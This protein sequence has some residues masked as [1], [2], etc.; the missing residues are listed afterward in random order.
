[1]TEFHKDP[2]KCVSAIVD[3]LGDEIVIATPLGLGKPIQLLNSFYNYAKQN[4]DV[5]LTI[6]SALS[7]AK[8]SLTNDLAKR[9][10]NPILKRLYDNYIELDY[11]LDRRAEKLPRNVQ[12]IEFY[13]S[14]GEY[15]HNS[16]AQQNYI[17]SNYTHVVRD[18][19]PY[20]INVIA[21]LISS[22]NKETDKYSLSCNADL[23]LDLIDAIKKHKGVKQNPLFLG[24]INQQLPYLYG[25]SAE[26]SEDQFFAIIDNQNTVTLFNI[27][28]P[29]VSPEDFM[30]GLY[31]SVL[32]KD[33][34][35]LQIGIGSLSDALVASLILRHNHNDN[36]IKMLEHIKLNEK[37]G[38][39]VNNVGETC[40]FKKGLFGSTEML[41]DGFLN[42]YQHHI[43]RKKVYDDVVL[44]KLLNNNLISEEVSFTTIEQLLAYKRISEKLTQDEFDFLQHYGIFKE[45]LQYQNGYIY[46][47]SKHKLYADLSKSKWRDKI[48]S[49]CLGDALKN[50]HLA[51]AG[52]FIGSQSL[53]E[54]L[55]N[56]SPEERK[57]FDMRG[58]KQ[59][60]QLYHSE[61][62]DALQRTN[63]R[64]VNSTMKVTL[65]GSAASDTLENGKVISG[66]GGQYNFVAMAHELAGARSIINCRSTY[67]KNGKV[68]SNILWEYAQT[69]IPRHLRDIVV[70]EYGI[71]DCRSKTDSDVIK[72]LLNISDSRFQ[73]EL[74]AKAKKAGKLPNDYQI[75]KPFKNNFP[76]TILQFL[77]SS[78]F[79]ECYQPY[80]FGTELTDDEVQIKKA[81]NYLKSLSGKQRFLCILK[82]LFKSS[83]PYKN[84]LVRMDLYNPKKIREFIYQFLLLSAFNHINH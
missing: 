41:V 46:Y 4:P 31:S 1:M 73:D 51:H 22:H 72:A 3:K 24:E 47:S 83:K 77:N 53:Y 60:N 79:K 13:L 50:G 55:R 35:C 62:I 74:L 5:Q 81:L 19:L 38:S 67:V 2:D 29:S 15:L 14:P 7:L 26:V 23:S 71:A 61:E 63:A 45:D 39:L 40:T 52:F 18:I 44:Q 48:K 42:L 10:V 56:M 78:D 57:L 28:R 65:L 16:N 17:C 6:I 59:L 25:E 70:T 69:T 82:G 21:Q 11:E 32:V 27:P 66:V 9:L 54:A 80:P 58:V 37:F 64:F 75:P 76:E 20:N 49:H 36:Y 8:P 12:V 33:D 43:L 84:V 34:G 30:I 68:Q